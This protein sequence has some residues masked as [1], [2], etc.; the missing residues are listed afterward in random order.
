M[1]PMSHQHSFNHLHAVFFIGTINMNL[2]FLDSVTLK[3]HVEIHC[4]GRQE[5]LTPSPQFHM[6]TMTG[7]DDPVPHGPK[8]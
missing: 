6:V 3:H 8:W 7:I 2:Y 4:Q 5:H 1:G